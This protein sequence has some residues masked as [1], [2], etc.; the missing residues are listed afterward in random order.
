MKL[1]LRLTLITLATVLVAGATYAAVQSGA[2]Q[3]L[4]SAQGGRHRPEFTTDGNAPQLLAG[5]SSSEFRPPA[6]EGDGEGFG[7][8]GE[9]EGGGWRG[10]GTVVRDL[11]IFAVLFVAVMGFSTLIARITRRRMKSPQPS[12]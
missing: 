1:I 10:L 2:L 6:F 11:G 4:L 8:R 9:R 5:E 12:S 7:A 3:N